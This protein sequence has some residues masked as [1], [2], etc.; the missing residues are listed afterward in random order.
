[1]TE[2][3]CWKNFYTFTTASADFPESR[4]AM[5]KRPLFFLLALAALVY[6]LVP[7]DLIPDFIPLLGLSDDAVVGLAG[8]L[9]LAGALKR[10]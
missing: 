5:K 8:L 2:A 4:G 1:M 9:S 3:K 7:T 6:I 10:S